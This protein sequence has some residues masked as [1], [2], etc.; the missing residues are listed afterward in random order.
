MSTDEQELSVDQQTP[1]TLQ[2]DYE[3]ADGATVVDNQDILIDV[4]F[5]SANSLERDSIG[6]FTAGEAV[7]LTFDEAMANTDGTTTS[8]CSSARPARRDLFRPG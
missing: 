7:P 2:A 5:G 8:S 6:V 4:N 3:S 1:F